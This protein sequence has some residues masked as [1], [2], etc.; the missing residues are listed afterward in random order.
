MK[1]TKNHFIEWLKGDGRG[2]EL[3][4]E[5]TDTQT[6]TRFQC[7]S[8]HQ[9]DAR[10][11]TIK[12]G[13]GCPGCAGQLPPSNE[14]AQE[15]LIVNHKNF[16]LVGDL[17]GTHKKSKFQCDLGHQWEAT[18]ANIRSGTGCPSC[19]S[20][21]LL[22]REEMIDW[23]S[24]NESGISI[25]GNYLGSKIKTKFCCSNGHQWEAT[26]KNIRAGKG[27]PSCADHSGGGFDPNKSAWEYVFTRGGYL[28]FGITNDLTRRLN[29][30]RR[31]GEVVLVHERYHEIG[32]I[33]LE[34]ETNIK[35]THGGRHVTKDQ[36][37][38]GWT[39][40]LP[41]HL[42]ESIMTL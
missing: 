13:N 17:Q 39:E 36:C 21:R 10:P 4:G 41:L 29:E 8:G 28:K 32:Q 38:D 37:P 27:C 11:N 26:P 6:K 5:Y 1:L 20:Q 23:L 31:H 35:R 18:F 19:S 9:W 30:H 12:Q 2:F 24:N 15:W 33:A 7:Q 25:S 34:W 22:T 3:V 42:L 40:T 16:T 14:E